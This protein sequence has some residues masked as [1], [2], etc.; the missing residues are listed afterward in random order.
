MRILFSFIGFIT[1]IKLGCILIKQ[2]K[3]YLQY[4][5]TGDDD[6]SIQCSYSSCMIRGVYKPDKDMVSMDSHSS[7]R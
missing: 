6:Y 1:L 3:D 7:D 5:Y 2:V 4:C